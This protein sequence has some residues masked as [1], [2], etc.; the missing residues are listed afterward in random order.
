MQEHKKRIL[1]HTCC[2][3]CASYVIELLKPDYDITLFFYNP[4]IEPEDEY[5][6]RKNE[7]SKLL[8]IV[9]SSQESSQ[10][11]LLNN[12]YDND[13]FETAVLPYHNQPEGGERCT[14]CFRIRLYET[15]KRAKAEKYD[16][17]TSTLSVSPH[18]NAKLLN[19]IGQS[20]ANEYKIDYLEADFK[21]KDGY[22]HSIKLTK[23]YNLYRQSYCGC[24]NS[25]LINQRNNRK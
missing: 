1:L 7:L 10:I 8:L 16:I 12:E 25:K 15:A 11:K 17:F 5:I 6:K 23:E 14:E 21:K 22:L 13:I 2:A 19:K 24:N 4:N 9:N 20:A 18:K 3:P